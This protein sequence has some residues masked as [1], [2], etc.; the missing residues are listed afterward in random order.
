MNTLEISTISVLHT[1]SK[2]NYEELSILLL[3]TKN[4]TLQEIADLRGIPLSEVEDHMHALLKK[5]EL[6]TQK[7]LRK[8]LDE[9]NLCH[10]LT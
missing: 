8:I 6:C 5:F 1:L 2:L 4:T 7:D 3:V 10:M 9:F